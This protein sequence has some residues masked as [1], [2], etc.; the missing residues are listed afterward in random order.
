MSEFQFNTTKA[1]IDTD[2]PNYEENLI[3]NAIAES[4]KYRITII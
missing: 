4:E 2:D 3:Y 1:E